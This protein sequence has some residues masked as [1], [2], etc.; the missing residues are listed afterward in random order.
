[1]AAGFFPSCKTRKSVESRGAPRESPRGRGGE[2]QHLQ[3]PFSAEHSLSIEELDLSLLS[4]GAVA[5][6]ALEGTHFF[7]FIRNVC[8]EPGSLPRGLQTLPLTPA[9]TLRRSGRHLTPKMSKRTC[10]SPILICLRRWKWAT[11]LTCRWDQNTQHPSRL[12]SSPHTLYQSHR[13]VCERQLSKDVL[14]GPPLTSYPASSLVPAT[15]IP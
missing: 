14:L 12:R 6:T 1:M 15:R 5:A 13:R 11:L 9:F 7:V 10:A 4:G 8:F 3:V 2:R